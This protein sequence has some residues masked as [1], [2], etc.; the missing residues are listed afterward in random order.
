LALSVYDVLLG[1]ASLSEARVRS[2]WG[3]ESGRQNIPTYDVLG[4]NRLDRYVA[5]DKLPAPPAGTRSEQRAV[6]RL[7]NS[8]PR[9]LDHALPCVVLVRIFVVALHGRRQCAVGE[10][11]SSYK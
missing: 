8:L 1:S 7:R 2:H 10:G 3:E 4:A 5:P 11:V 6:G 9:P